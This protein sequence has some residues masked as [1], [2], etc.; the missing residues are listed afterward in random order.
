MADSTAAGREALAAGRDW[1]SG[2]PR[3]AVAHAERGAD[4]LAAVRKLLE[5]LGNPHRQLRVIHVAG[6]KGKGSTAL[7]I[8]ALLQAGGQRTFT[9][10][11]PHLERW[12]ERLRIDGDEAEPALA[13]RA[14]ESVQRA[15]R[16]T[17]ITPGFF[18]ALTV[19]GLW[20]AAETC[21]DWAIVEAGVGGRADATNVVESRLSLITGI[22]LEHTDRLGPTL[23]AIAREKAG[24]VKP[25]IPL[26]APAL[27]A[28]IDAILAQASHDAGSEF[29]RLR[30]S[31]RPPRAIE[32]PLEV[33]WHQRSGLLQ[34][35]G[36][37]WSV[38]TPLQASGSAMAG[39]AALALAATARLG[40]F[41]REALQQGARALSGLQL[42]G[43]M[44]TVSTL[45]WVIV[46]GAHTRAS[47]ESLADAVR[48]LAPTRVHLLLSISHGK[49][50]GPVLEALLAVADAAT[51][52]RADPAYSADPA[53]LAELAYRQRPDLA[54]RIE[55][56]PEQALG[57]A[58]SDAPGSTLVLATGSVYL[59]GR[60]RGLLNS[61]G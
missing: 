19:A 4:P 52:T 20:L 38:R 12:T 58:A 44:E 2:L 10:T 13:L 45:P 5:A 47:A 11:S 17:G 26:L 22:E 43:R 33:R 3:T 18:E 28:S 49:D 50:A 40:L 35:A 6:S 27:P 37:G 59:A 53:Q 16:E 61:V 8:E 39:N 54:G 23:E 31:P 60:I 30:P 48:E 55:P 14:L 9:F 46:D 1:L 51:F 21:V 41:S 36:S 57:H 7:Y 42:P 32:S 15:Q 56:D 24:I 25:G 34:V 29:V